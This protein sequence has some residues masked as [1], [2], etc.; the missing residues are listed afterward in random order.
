MGDL[1]PGL[2]RFPDY[3]KGY[4]LQ[5]SCMEN[6]MDKGYKGLDMTEKL[7]FFRVSLKES[8]AQLVKD[9]PA[10]QKTLV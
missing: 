10:I 2:Q 9:T 3:G 5:Y 6:S 1:G 4:P 8:V 7:T